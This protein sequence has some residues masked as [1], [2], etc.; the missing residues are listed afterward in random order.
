MPI[1]P[2]TNRRTLVYDK[3]VARAA[4]LAVSHPDA[5]GH[6]GQDGG[7]AAVGRFLAPEPVARRQTHALPSAGAEAPL[8]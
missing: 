6:V 4:L 8:S 2:G 3:D 7:H 5:A 1:G